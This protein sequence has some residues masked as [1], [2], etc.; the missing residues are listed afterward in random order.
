M[1]PFPDVA[2]A[3][4]PAGPAA[5]KSGTWT[6]PGLCGEARVTTAFGE[7][8]VK[9]LR[10]LDPV[11]TASGSFLPVRW[12]DAVHLDDDFLSGFPDA[13]PISVPAG[14][15]GRGRP[16]VDLLVSP[17]QKLSSSESSFRPEFRMA[18]D[19]LSRPGILRRP[20]TS[21]SYYLFHL[22]EPASVMVEGVWIPV[23]P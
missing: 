13:Q 14:A 23:I 11:R 20:R 10:R 17:H 15:L 18:R 22:G 12:V 19:F 8:P 9:A 4:P 21:V 5:S 1:Y 16:Q 6:L 2:K 7:L 3:T